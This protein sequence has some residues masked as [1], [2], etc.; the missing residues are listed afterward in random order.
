MHLDSE[1]SPLSHQVLT[2][3]ERWVAVVLRSWPLVY[4]NKRCI[5]APVRSPSLTRI[6]SSHLKVAQ[7]STTE[8]LNLCTTTF[9]TGQVCWQPWSSSGGGSCRGCW[10]SRRLGSTSSADAS[11]CSSAGVT[12]LKHEEPVLFFFLLFLFCHP[13]FTLPLWWVD[14]MMYE[15][16]LFT[17]LL[18]KARLLTSRCK[19]AEYC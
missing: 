14:D 11:S 1:V 12:D 17:C 2:A 8:H 13:F 15:C 10:G 9:L 19:K 7:L 3:C 16:S 6:I 4:I 18:W 5:S